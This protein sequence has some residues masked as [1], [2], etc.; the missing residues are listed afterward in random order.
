MAAPA[1]WR[2]HESSDCTIR[3]R[4][5]ADGSFVVKLHSGAVSIRANVPAAQIAFLFGTGSPA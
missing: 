3:V 5:L 1:D 2:T 4:R